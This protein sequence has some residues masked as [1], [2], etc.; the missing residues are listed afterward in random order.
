MEQQITGKHKHCYRSAVID[1]PIRYGQLFSKQFTYFTR[2]QG[3]DVIIIPLGDAEYKNEVFSKRHQLSAN[4]I[5]A[6]DDQNPTNPPQQ[7]RERALMFTSYT[8]ERNPIAA[9]DSRM[10]SAAQGHR[11]PLLPSVTR[12][13]IS[14]GN[15]FS[16]ST[17]R[18]WTVVSHFDGACRAKDRQMHLSCTE[19]QRAVKGEGSWQRCVPKKHQIKNFESV[20]Q[21]FY[22]EF[23][24]SFLRSVRSG[25]SFI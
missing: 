8:S 15:A 13:T 9:G 11:L 10:P 5:S 2:Q 17:W 22:W 3:P 14:A 4:H 25:S 21:S 18:R 7:L 20:I 19:R 1:L 16:G 24:R 23:N 6:D 12:P